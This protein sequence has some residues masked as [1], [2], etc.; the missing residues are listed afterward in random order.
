LKD[1]GVQLIDEAPRLG[2]RGHQVAFIHPR[3]AGGILVEL[4]EAPASPNA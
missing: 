4:V 1:R 2:A 3:S